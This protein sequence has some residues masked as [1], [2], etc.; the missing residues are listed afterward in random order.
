[1]L[2]LKI[3]SGKISEHTSKTVGTIQNEVEKRAGPPWAASR[4][5]A[6]SNQRQRGRLSNSLNKKV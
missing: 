6:E 2:E 4:K 3:D 5:L 1:M